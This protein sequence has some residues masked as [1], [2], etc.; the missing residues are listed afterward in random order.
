MTPMVDC[1]RAMA[2]RPLGSQSPAPGSAEPRRS[3]P[4]ISSRA[5]RISSSE[6]L[7]SRR[8]RESRKVS[9][10]RR[11]FFIKESWASFL[12]LG[13]RLGMVRGDKRDR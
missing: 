1:L 10:E 6:L 13:N 2:G 3:D 7:E 8:R 11:S 9:E 4:S 12:E 5:D